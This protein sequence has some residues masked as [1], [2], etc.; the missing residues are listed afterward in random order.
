MHCN[1]TPTTSGTLRLRGTQQ[2]KPKQPQQQQVTSHTLHRYSAI[3]AWIASSSSNSSSNSPSR[4]W[5]LELELSRTAGGASPRRGCP[6]PP[7]AGAPAPTEVG[8][9]GGRNPTSSCP[10]PRLLRPP[11]PPP[12][13]P[14]R[15]LLR[16]SYAA[17]AEGSDGKGAGV[18]GTRPRNAFGTRRGFTAT[19]EGTAPRVGA[20][21]RAAAALLGCFP[22][23]NLLSSSL[24]CVGGSKGSGRRG[25]GHV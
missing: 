25:G 2:K 7:P 24:L 22:N 14:P 5:W 18:A 10:A 4:S 13:P 8:G 20:G 16:V 6:L 15:P 1:T 12:P 11:P 23:A 17:R 19:A 9:G 21:V 3:A